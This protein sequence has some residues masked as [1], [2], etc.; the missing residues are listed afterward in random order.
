MVSYG[1]PF[2][3]KIGGSAAVTIGDPMEYFTSHLQDEQGNIWITNLDGLYKFD[4]KKWT[5]FNKEQLPSDICNKV[6]ESSDN[7]IW[8]ATRHGIAKQVGNKW[9]KYEKTEA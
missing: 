3:D 4:G 1:I 6:I 8:V 2:P 7:E 9:V 5:N